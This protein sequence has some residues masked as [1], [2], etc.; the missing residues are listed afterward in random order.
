MIKRT[1]YQIDAYHMNDDEARESWRDVAR[2]I[3]EICPEAEVFLESAKS[4]L[5]ILR[6]S[7]DKETSK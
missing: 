6:V 2:M 3:E 1:T 4:D 5:F 7:I